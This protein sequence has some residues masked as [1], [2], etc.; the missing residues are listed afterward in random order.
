MLTLRL[1]IAYSPI[2]ATNKAVEHRPTPIEHH[3]TPPETPAVSPPRA[4]Q[5]DFFYPQIVHLNFDGHRID[6][7]LPEV[8]EVVKAL[9]QR[10]R[11][12]SRTFCNDY[13]LTGH[14]PKP[15]CPHDHNPGLSAEEVVALAKR[16]RRQ[17]CN[18][19]GQCRNDRC[20]YGHYCEHDSQGRCR[21]GERCFL[22][23]FHGLKIM[24]VKSWEQ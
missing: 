14:C 3:P 10:M 7:Q 13:N 11:S 19:G 22:K 4:Q 1:Y 9:E 23:R 8:T 21:F 12:N 6:G 15:S 17:P 5:Q 24:D 20:I 18:R 16:A 2:V